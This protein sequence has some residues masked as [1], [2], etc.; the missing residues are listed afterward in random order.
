MFAK[1][2][3][4]GIDHQSLGAVGMTN[5]DKRT[6]LCL[7]LLGAYSLGVVKTGVSLMG[8][9]LDKRE[10]PCESMITSKKVI[11]RVLF[12]G[13]FPIGNKH[14]SLWCV[15]KFIVFTLRRFNRL[16]LD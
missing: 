13:G 6:E 15:F 16:L 5:P 10:C 9:K 3:G 12:S 1:I 11:H 4:T 8:H 2:V 14:P 7:Y